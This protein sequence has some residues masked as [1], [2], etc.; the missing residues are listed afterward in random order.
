MISLE[1]LKGSCDCLED[2]TEEEFAPLWEKFL[3]FLSQITC[4]NN[5]HGTILVEDRVE[6]IPLDKRLCDYGCLDIQPYYKNIDL[7]TVTMEVRQYSSSGLKILPV[8]DFNYDEF[9]D[10]FYININH[11]VGC[12]CGCDCDCDCEKNMLVIRYQ[13]GYELDT[14]EWLDLICHYFTGYMAVAN[15]CISVDDC[16][17]QDQKMIGAR[18]KTKKVDVISYT[19]EVDENSEEVFFTKL[20][21]NYYIGLLSKYAL[22]GR[23]YHVTGNMWIGKDRSN[24][25][26]V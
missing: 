2:I 18:L 20:M 13:A 26:I 5:P 12:D 8:T 24:E 9:S 4:W 14:P 22:C 17:S 10:R 6:S 3:R 25:T 16:C 1:M 23:G 19:W 11:A 21:H 15:D 7:E